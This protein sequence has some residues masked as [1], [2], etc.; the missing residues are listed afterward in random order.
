MSECELLRGIEI[1]DECHTLFIGLARCFASAPLSSTEPELENVAGFSAANAQSRV[2]N[3]DPQL[4]ERLEKG[5]NIWGYG[6][7]G[8]FG[9]HLKLKFFL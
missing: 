1:Y 7:L 4:E 5:R 6:T 3:I 9:H 8:D 2:N